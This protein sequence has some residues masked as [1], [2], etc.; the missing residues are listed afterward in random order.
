M[1]ALLA[2]VISFFGFII[3]YRL[4][5]RFISRRIFRLDDTRITPSHQFKDGVDFV[6]TDKSIIFGHHFTSIAGAGPIVG[7]AIAVIWG[8][9]PAM[10][11]VVVGSILI[12][13]V[14]DLGSLVISLRHEGKSVGHIAHTVINPTVKLLYLILLFFLLVLVIAVFMLIISLLFTMY[15]A[16]V[17]PIWFEIP[18]AVLFGY[19]VHKRKG[20]VLLWGIIAL[21]VMYVSIFF[22]VSSPAL[23]NFHI[24]PLM[25]S[26][27]LSW[28]VLL[29]IYCFI[30]SVLPVQVLLQPR[31]YINSHQLFAALAILFGG[32]II[33]HPE[34]TAPMINTNIPDAPSILPFL[35]ITVAC[36]AVSGFHSLI[37]S[38]T[39]VKQLDRERDALPVGYGS[40]LVEGALAVMVILACT[41][42]L[43]DRAAW[44]EH[45]AS[46]ASASG[47][48]AKIDAF[49]I[50]GA[51]FME[52]VGL[53]TDIGS[54]IIAVMVVSFAATSLDTSTRILR[55]ITA[56]LA[57]SWSIKPLQ[58]RYAATGFGLTAVLALSVLPSL[59]TTGKVDGSGGMLL[60]PLFGTSNQL[61]AGLALLVLTIW[62][63]KRKISI[64]YTFLPLIFLLAITAWAMVINFSIFYA[65]EQ[66]HLIFVGIIIIVIEILMVIQAVKVGV[67]IRRN[68]V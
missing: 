26:E 27:I 30:T 2:A 61:L 32:L 23:S 3:G 64:W 62:L 68:R 31:D 42:G 41:A 48:G 47:L 35:F 19:I 11:W 46:W 18:L 29:L 53:K 37:S 20:G 44:T 13:G 52:G 8:W 15:P 67:S 51:A 66:F 63:A 6:P 16:S 40:M 55:Y 60:W 24:P 49:I 4:Y 33:V 56:E 45:Y 14:H 59:L 34:I 1:N 21:Y 38:G 54:A 65:K 25:G 7:P 12:G 36:G 57:K 50:G 17:F 43:G 10:I 39:T 5:G 22:S 9:L 28:T 58:N